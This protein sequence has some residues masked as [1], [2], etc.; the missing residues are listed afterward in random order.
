MT[1]PLKIQL[2]YKTRGTIK[3][4]T[5]THN[6]SSMIHSQFFFPFITYFGYFHTIK[7][8]S[9]EKA[10]FHQRDHR[11]RPTVPAVS[12]FYSNQKIKRDP[13]NCVILWE[14]WPHSPSRYSSVKHPYGFQLKSVPPSSTSCWYF[15]NHALL[16]GKRKGSW[17]EAPEMS[18][19]TSPLLTNVVYGTSFKGPK[20]YDVYSTD[21]K[22][23]RR[24][25]SP[26]FA[27]VFHWTGA[28]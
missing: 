10:L 8:I 25:I 24:S 12:R 22:S 28:S 6:L 11:K 7:N 17:A 3:N 1:R 15:L 14:I 16:T 23:T 19:V 4:V 2:F 18:T 13:Q 27:F 9:W 5:V 20:L 26:L 21:D